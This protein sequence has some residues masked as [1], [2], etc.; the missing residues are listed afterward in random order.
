MKK[1]LRLS[2]VFLCLIFFLAG[3]VISTSTAAQ[4]PPQY[5]T[6]FAGVPDPR[7]VTIYQVNMR[8]FSPT[9]NLQGVINRLD[10]IKALGVNVIYLMPVYPVGVLKS[11]NSPYCIRSFD[12]VGTEFGALSDLQNLVDG[13]HSRN[14]AVILDWVVNQTSW[15]HPWITEHPDWYLQDSNGNIEQLDGYS[16][17]AALNFSNTAMRIAMITAMKSW[18]YRANVDGFRCDFADNPPIDFWQQT[19]DTLRNITTH[20]L[21]LLAEGSR[22]A[23]YGAGFDYN[24]GFQFYGSSLQPIFM[25]GPVT[26]IDVSD[27]VEY[28]GASGTNQIVRYL[29]NHDVD[30]TDGPPVSQFGGIPGSTAAFVVVAY[31]KGIPFVYNG[32]EE[33]FPTPITF[34][35]LSVTINW[36]INPAVTTA[37]QQ[38]IAFRDSSEAI[39][40]GSLVSYDN[41]DICAFTRTYGSQEVVVLVN[42][43]NATINYPIPAALQQT[44][45][46]NEFTGA[47]TMLGT[48]LSLSPYQYLVLTNANVPVV[49]VTGVSVIPTR[50]T[51]NAGLTAQLTAMVA[52]ANASNQAVSWTSGNTAVATVSAAGL[53]TGVAAGTTV[54][55]VMTA[56]QS[57]T[58]NDTVVVEP[59][60]G[61]TVNF[62]QPTG[63]GS[64]INIYWWDAQ[65]AGILA[66]GTW[67]GVPMTSKGNGWYSYTFNNIDSTN[68]IFNDGTNQTANLARGS[69]GWYYNDTWYD[70]LPTI[71]SGTTYYQILNRWQP[72][73]YLYDGGT[74]KVLY[75]TN[76]SA[77]DQTY[78][79]T[80]VNAG[81][82]YVFLQNRST[83]NY[84]HVQDQTGYVECGTINTVWY[85]AMWAFANAGSGWSYIQNRWQSNQWIHIQDLLG[86]AEYANA[87][88]GWYSA[89]WQLVNP[90]TVPDETNDALRSGLATGFPGDSV[91]A[92]AIQLFPNPASGGRFYISLPAATGNSPAWITIHDVNGKTLLVTQLTGSGEIDHP[93]PAG[94]YFVTIRTGRISTT[95]KLTVL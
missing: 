25:G 35:Y 42:L 36:G 74:G 4:Y 94:T 23:N 85:S 66:D 58:A 49:M 55:T 73:T 95:K 48:S 86:Y 70:T 14:M 30:G 53:V 16:D 33:A 7:D 90:V 34:P 76:P 92:A 56:D 72:N 47:S 63:W 64:G 81:S 41:N 50:D 59:A 27:S 38:I 26:D 43:R 62:Y 5:G 91:A 20:K 29:T 13:A 89:M 32:T 52:P 60:S 57:K 75:G 84:M 80:E 17:V 40:R 71:P 69:N 18:V 44:T 11:V 45:W 65:P 46:N 93:L 24:F 2:N 61:F 6:P 54:I 37:Y 88:T 15:D 8:A 10:S 77:G 83:G 21:L 12:S 3:T 28:I 39:R 9:H 87:Q 68:L 82:G 79:W 51:V 67:P 78:Q 1:L 19:I 31:R 22:S